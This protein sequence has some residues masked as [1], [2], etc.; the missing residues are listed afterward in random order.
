MTR[1]NLDWELISRRFRERRKLFGWSIDE[2]A[3]KAKVSRDTVMR[4]EKG[5]PISDKSLHAL[6]SSYALF[7]AQLISHVPDSEHYS[8]CTTEQIRWMS[9]TPRDHKGRRVKNIDYSFVDDPAERKR[10]ATLGYQRFFTGFIRSELDGGVMSS[11]IMEIYQLSWTDRH[12][13]EEF[14]YCLSGEAVITVEGDPC[15]LKAGDSIVFDALKGHSYAPKEG[16]E[17]PAVILFVVATRPD[18][19]ERVDAMLPPRDDWGV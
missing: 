9:A 7:S 12:F 14:V 19:G 17:L 15:H 11:G 2:V 3:G 5:R 18:E 6:R 10:R 13:G 8:N 16:S 4:A 1:T